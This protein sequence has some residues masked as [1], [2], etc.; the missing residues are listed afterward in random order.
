MFTL[1]ERF[2]FR[3][4]GFLLVI[5][6]LQQLQMCFDVSTPRIVPQDEKAGNTRRTNISLFL[7]CSDLHFKFDEGQFTNTSLDFTMNVYKTRQRMEILTK[8]LT[9]EGCFECDMVQ[10]MMDAMEQHGA[11]FLDI[12]SNVGLYSLAAASRGH[13]A[14]AFEPFRRNWERICRSVLHTPAWLGLVH[15]IPMAVSNVTSQTMR[16]QSWSKNRGSTKVVKEPRRARQVISS[17]GVKGTETVTL[18]SIQA[19]LLPLH[20]PLVLKVDVE[21]HECAALHGALQHVFATRTIVHMSIEWSRK[22]LEECYLRDSIFDVL[23]GR[24]GLRPY[25]RM[26]YDNQ[27]MLLDTGDWRDWKGGLEL[28]LIEEQI[29]DTVWSLLNLNNTSPMSPVYNGSNISTPS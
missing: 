4:A 19:R 11:I 3:S 18:D 17:D 13:V 15:V 25:M 24:H 1:R 10:L 14:Y 8:I 27:W 16:I 2:G 23:Q 7:N 12:G 28:D 6:V 9:E 21:G 5:W 26:G 20:K 22:R 29:Y